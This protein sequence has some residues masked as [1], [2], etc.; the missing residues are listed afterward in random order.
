MSK[1]FVYIDCSVITMITVICRFEGLN[2]HSLSKKRVT[3]LKIEMCRFTQFEEKESF[4][5]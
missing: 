5:W 4:L 3:K 2:N 1:D